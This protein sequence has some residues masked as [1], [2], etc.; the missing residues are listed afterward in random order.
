MRLAAACALLLFAVASSALVLPCERNATTCVVRDKAFVV[1]T[2]TRLDLV[3]DAL[4]FVNTSVRIAKGATFYLNITGSFTLTTSVIRGFDITVY[5]ARLRI[6]ETSSINATATSPPAGAAC[7]GT[8]LFGIGGNSSGIGGCFDGCPSLQ[9]GAVVPSATSVEAGRSGW[10]QV[11]P[12]VFLPCSEGGGI[13]RLYTRGDMEVLGSVLADGA[14]ASALLV[15]GGCGGGGGGT[16]F[17]T[18]G[19]AINQGPRGVLSARGG[20]PSGDRPAGGGGGGRIIVHC[21][22]P[23]AACGTNLRTLLAGGMAA[24]DRAPGGTGLLYTRINQGSRDST[25]LTCA[26]ASPISIVSTQPT[27]LNSGPITSARFDPG[28]CVCVCVEVM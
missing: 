19:A 18:S 24:G 4:T 22:S 17:L 25:A 20:L 23:N 26:T 12:G 1:S 14:N 8:A 5:S 9:G 28:A 15:N 21:E 11:R 2:S 13:V 7:N 16:V 3:Y 10:C 6:E 27:V